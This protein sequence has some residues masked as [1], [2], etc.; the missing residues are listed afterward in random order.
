MPEWR[1]TENGLWPLG[2]I[3]PAVLRDWYSEDMLDA[4]RQV[5]FSSIITLI[6]MVRERDERIKELEGSEAM[7]VATI[8]ETESLISDMSAQRDK[9]Q[10]ALCAALD[11]IEV[12]E[13]ER[14]EMNESE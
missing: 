10:D 3:D 5:I 13:N 1:Q 12:R 8:E 9:L 11:Q 14:W 7:S 4:V 6:R 2:I